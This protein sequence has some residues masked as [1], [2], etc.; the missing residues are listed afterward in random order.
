MKIKP[1]TAIVALLLIGIGG[2]VVGRNFSRNPAGVTPNDLAE[3]RQA[4]SSSRNS[5]GS[6]D[7][8]T[9]RQ[10][11]RGDRR[12]KETREE[13]LARLDKIVRGEDPL[14][15]SRSLL[16]WI[17]QLGPGDF[18]E[19]VSHFRDL[20]ITDNRL[21]EYSLLL[22]AWAQVDPVA[23]ITYA[24]DQTSGN[25]ASDA[26][27][28]AWAARDPEAAIRWAQGNHTGDEANPNLPGIIRGLAELDAARATELLTSMTFG[29][30][31]GRGLDFIL[32][33]L[34]QQ[35]PEATRAWIATLKD[36]TLRNGAMTRAA[37]QLAEADP[38]GTVA[39]LLANPGKASEEKM[40]DVYSQWAQKDQ[41]AALA[42]FETVQGEANRSNA[43]RGLVRKA[44]TED[45]KVGISLMN[46]YPSDVNDRV[47][48]SF[49]WH[50]F[51]KDA[52]TAVGQISRI[53]DPKRQDR[54]YRRTLDAWLKDDPRSANAWIRVNP[55]PQP[56]RD[57]LSNRQ[58]DRP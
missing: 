28:T 43:L 23:A 39:W 40:D 38:A 57:Y 9:A 22:T 21:G 3:N 47:V 11:A 56:I 4:R 48:Q 42:S 16:A 19:A 29:N 17:D 27:L 36:D 13:Q 52:S 24:K 7:S 54:M 35:G 58:K 44:T 30:D 5:E 51:G 8:G 46:R 14:E 45:P 53:E 37:D 1:I 41:S 20:G 34:L 31:R 12:V 32:P 50:A 6:E 55:L 33:H 10:S 18:A 25:F 2:F 15:R 26:I 49:I